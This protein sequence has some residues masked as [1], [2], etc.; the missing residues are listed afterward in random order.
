[1]CCGSSRAVGI[2][3][4]TALLIGDDDGSNPRYV[5]V[6]DPELLPG[7]GVGGQVFVRGSAVQQAFDD[8]KI[9]DVSRGNRSKTKTTFRVTLPD[10][11]KQD[12]AAYAT[13]NSYAR[14]NKGTVMVVKEN[15]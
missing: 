13:A 2:R 11:S 1:M 15:A 3:P 4:Q 8:G 5:R 9:E 12:F 14:R 7:V 10:G 6:N